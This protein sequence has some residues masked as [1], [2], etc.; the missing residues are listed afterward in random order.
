MAV[1][2]IERIVEL[3]GDDVLRIS[4]ASS[5]WPALGSI[6]VAGVEE[7]VAV[8]AST[9]TLSH[10][11]TDDAERRFQNPD[12]GRPIQGDRGRRLFLLGLWE[13]DPHERVPRPPLSPQTRTGVSGR[14]TRFSIFLRL[15]TLRAALETG[16]EQETTTSD[17]TIRCLLPSL[18]PASYSAHRD[19]V[20]PDVTA[21]RVAI[22]GSGILSAA[23]LRFQPLRSA[24]AAPPARS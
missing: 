3:V 4:D 23:E 11:G 12:G 2:I 22:D 10:R 5:R 19:G 15:A 16:W 1:A 13:S 14:Q 9:V 6:L 20:S 8:Y 17:E 21:M 7:P 24:R 18:L